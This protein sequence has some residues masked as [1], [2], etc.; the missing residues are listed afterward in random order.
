MS[1]DTRQPETNI[2]EI[3]QHIESDDDEDSM[4]VPRLINKAPKLRGLDRVQ[5]LSV[6]A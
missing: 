3:Q 1:Q 6:S 5:C 4:Q 2:E